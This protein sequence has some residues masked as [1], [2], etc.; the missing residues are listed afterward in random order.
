MRG[1]RLDRQR[2]RRQ[3]LTGTAR[4]LRRAALVALAAGLAIA[5]SSA[6][7]AAS[8]YRRP[9]SG[10]DQWYWELSPP[11][12]GLAGLPAV[13]APYP[14]PGSA[15][16]WDTDLFQDAG[17]RIP[18]GR[19]A[20]V[21][22]LHAAGH[23]S[24]CYIDA[25]AYEAG[26]PDRR[27]YAPA[28]YGNAARRYAMRGWPGEW[29]L[30]IAGFRHYVAGRP[31]TLRGAAVNIATAV[32]RRIH[33]CAL[34]GQDALEPDDLDGYTNRGVTGAR[35]GGWRLTRADSAGFERWLAWRAHRD[36][37]AILQK[38]D[39]AD[40]ARNAATFDGM[41]LEECHRY[42]DPCAGPHGDATPYLRAGKPVLNAEYVQDGE[43]TGRFC[44]ADR[45]AGI[46]GAL[47]DL[48]LDGR[49]YRPC[50]PAGARAR[51]VPGQGETAT[52]RTPGSARRRPG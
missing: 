10:Q 40:A 6:V 32:A 11:R 24:V 26:R 2:V 22:A 49:V 14:Q 39:A 4:P 16:I 20:V 21:A 17:G 36:G 48:D 5:A 7:A 18:T 23:Y 31:G 46:T 51:P 1:R 44:A 15:N 33:W 3:G 43:T 19:S 52:P 9:P 13:S 35:G 50:A 47:F 37:L 25:G 34:E 12:P 45:R 41:I 27:D 42:R 8:S 28:D 29:W 38:N 30:N